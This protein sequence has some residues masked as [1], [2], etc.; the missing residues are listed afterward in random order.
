MLMSGAKLVRN[1]QDALDVLYG[2][3]ART[4]TDQSGESTALGSRLTHMLERVGAGEDTIAKLMKS[5][6]DPGEVAI[7]LAE[8]ELRGLLVRGDAGRYVPSARCPAAGQRARHST[9]SLL[10]S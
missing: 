8:L 10:Y 7:A 2:V 1:A 4:V 9:R 5:G 3:G 6:S